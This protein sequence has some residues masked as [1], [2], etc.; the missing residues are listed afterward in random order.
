MII[1]VKYINPDE[2]DDVFIIY[3]II[4][5]FNLQYSLVYMFNNII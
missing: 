3:F 2:E 5:L 4:Y 1:I